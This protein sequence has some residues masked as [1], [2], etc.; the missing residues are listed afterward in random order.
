MAKIKRKKSA[1]TILTDIAVEEII[2]EATERGE[3]KL[4]RSL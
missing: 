4:I 2:K 1:L 3:K